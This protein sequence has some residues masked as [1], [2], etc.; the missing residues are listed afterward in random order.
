MGFWID[1]EGR[2]SLTRLAATV[3]LVIVALELIFNTIAIVP[4]GYRGV[5]LYMGAVENRVLVEGFHTITPFLESYRVMEVRT[6]KYEVPCESSSKDLLDVRTTVAIN[7]HIDPASVNTIYQK[8]SENYQERVIA[9]QVQE[10][11]KSVT[12]KYDAQ[13]LIQTRENVKQDIDTLLKQRMLERDILVETISII[14]FEFPLSFN[15]AITSKQ[16]QVQKAQEAENKV[17]EIQA[18]AQQAVAQ[19]EGQAKAI[20]IINDQLRNSPDYIKWLSVTRWDGKLPLFLGNGA[21]PFID[22]QSLQASQAQQ[23]SN[24]STGG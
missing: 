5:V 8:L 23:N 18:V 10:V 2:L 1:K 15:D 16:T 11:V 7:Y 13:G 24:T 17:K 6:Q 3:V 14:N 4:A 20:Q 22:L 21:T 19:A 12:A 9:P